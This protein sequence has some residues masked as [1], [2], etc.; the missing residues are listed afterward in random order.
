[1]NVGERVRLLAMRQQMLE[2]DLAKIEVEHGIDLGRRPRKSPIADTEYYPQFSEQIRHEAAEMSRHYQVFY[3]LEKS[4]R[5]LVSELMHAEKGA[6]WWEQ[7]VPEN[8][9]RNASAAKNREAESAVTARST[10]P[11]DYTTFGELG[12]IVRNNWDVFGGVFNNDKAFTRVMSS[13]NVLRGPIAH[14]S[15]LAPDEVD[16]LS[17]ALRDWFRLME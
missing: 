17:L 1:M 15:A 3:C 10:E 7:C 13:L 16:R 6:D 5:E 11:L 2:A 14:C 8:V 4:I 12:E 9:R